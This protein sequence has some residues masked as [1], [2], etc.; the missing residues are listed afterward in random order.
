MVY[1]GSWERPKQYRSS[2]NGMLRNEPEGIKSDIMTVTAL[3]STPWVAICN[4]IYLLTYS[5]YENLITNGWLDEG[6]DCFWKEVCVRQCSRSPQESYR[7]VTLM[8]VADNGGGCYTEVATLN[9]DVTCLKLHCSTL[10]ISLENMWYLYSITLTPYC[11]NEVL[12]TM[13]EI[14]APASAVILQS[15]TNAN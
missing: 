12:S 3:Q 8:A 5:V 9:N 4:S 6:L 2:F 7:L 11:S 13:Y 10:L 15:L 1:D 14:F